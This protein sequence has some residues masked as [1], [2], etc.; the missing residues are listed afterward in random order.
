MAH[1]STP[2][3]TGSKIVG[4]VQTITMTAPAGYTHTLYFEAGNGV[5]NETVTQ[6]GTSYN[7]I[8]PLDFAR[9]TTTGRNFRIDITCTTY[10][11]SGR[12]EG[13]KS[14]Y[15]TA[16]IPNADPFL[17]EIT[18]ISYYDSAVNY[19]VI[20]ST[21][22]IMVQNKSKPT[23]EVETKGTYE[24]KISD[25]WAQANNEYTSYG[26]NHFEPAE[27]YTFSIGTGAIKKS[28]VFPVKINI[29]D[30]RGNN[31]N[32][33]FN[34]FSVEPYFSPTINEFTVLRCNYL[35]V[36]K[37]DGTYVK[38]KFSASVAPIANKNSRQYTV[39]WRESTSETFSGS[40]PVP[41]TSTYELSSE[42]VPSSGNGGFKID[43][44]YIFEA[45]AS[46]YFPEMATQQSIVPQSGPVFDVDASTQGIAFGKHVEKA[47]YLDTVWPIK[48]PAAELADPLP[49][50][51]GGT[52]LGI[53]P[54]NKLLYGNGA[55]GFATLP[56]PETTDMYLTQKMD[57]S[58]PQ[59]MNISMSEVGIEYGSWTPT[60]TN[61]TV[62]S[63]TF[64][65]GK[66][67]RFQEYTEGTLVIVFFSM[68]FKAASSFSGQVTIGGLPYSI[69]VTAGG[70]GMMSPLGSGNILAGFYANA[71]G[72]TFGPRGTNSL[73]NFTAITGIANGNYRIHGQMVYLT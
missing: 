13:T 6:V 55:N 37:K 69:L 65:N 45:R 42:W 21:W 12:K 68:E 19:G 41:N 24:S 23:F 14:A 61:G 8:I 50:N 53:F 7:W 49:V 62:S 1:A 11:P 51:S 3:L 66:Y 43:K 67:I 2:V 26:S 71:G 5:Y 27:Q 64:R 18:N 32:H 60:I 59:W 15:F 28:G 40:F 16:T 36:E 73:G 33:E 35:G 10:N 25:F 29:H 44:S 38:I 39:Y 48:A 4:E 46:D 31:L 47:G 72:K 54:V 70:S 20:P 63:W 22:G 57:G 58:P 56:F 34:A 30:S 52:G 17:P 9:A